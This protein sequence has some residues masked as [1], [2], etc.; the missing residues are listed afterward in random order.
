MLVFVDI[1]S[2]KELCSD[3]YP[4]TDLADGGILAVE[5]KRITVE[6]AEVNIGG[7]ASAGGGEE[8][9]EDEGV[10]KQGPQQ[11]I[12]LLHAFRYSEQSMSKKDFGDLF[13]NYCKELVSA[14]QKKK[15]EALGG[16]CPED[17]AEAKELE[18]KLKAEASKWDLAAYQVID[19]QLTA[20]KKRFKATQTWVST[21]IMG[22]AFKEYTFY[23]GEECD[24]GVGM[25]IAARYVPE[26]APSPTF[27]FFNDGLL[28]QK[29]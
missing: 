19:D 12:D 21:N 18:A 20:F 24:Y 17:A 4:T 22:D 28:K 3:S 8:P 1:V 14:Y 16:T 5:S 7:N 11:V 25:V 27:Y 15:I 6:E 10:D 13:K 9:V 23:M 29:A 26:D 2:G